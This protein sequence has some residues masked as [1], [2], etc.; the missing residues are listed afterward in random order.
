MFIFYVKLAGKIVPIKCKSY[1]SDQFLSTH[2]RLVGVEDIQEAIFPKFNIDTFI[3]KKSDIEYYVGGTHKEIEEE[4]SNE[5]QE[6][7]YFEEESESESSEEQEQEPEPE[8]EPK[9]K[10]R[11]RS[12]F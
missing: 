2:A 11:R 3:I 4:A 10:R 9:Q 8:P 7:E 5:N 1:D 6:E 12:R